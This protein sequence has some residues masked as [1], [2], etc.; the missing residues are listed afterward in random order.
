MNK[1][2]DVFLPSETERREEGSYTGKIPAASSDRSLFESF[3]LIS[4]FTLA[5]TREKEGEEE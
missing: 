5:A 1:S 2:I 3:S 4:C